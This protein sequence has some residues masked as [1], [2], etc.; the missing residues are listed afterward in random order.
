MVSN[1]TALWFT[2][3]KWLQQT[4]VANPAMPNQIAISF[5]FVLFSVALMLLVWRTWQS[6]AFYNAVAGSITVLMLAGP[7]LQVGSAYAYHGR[8]APRLETAEVKT[9]EQVAEESI[10]EYYASEAWHPQEN[11]LAGTPDTLAVP[12]AESHSLVARHSSLV[13]SNTVTSTLDTDNDGVSD[14]LEDLL[15]LCSGPSGTYCTGVTDSTD[16]DGD[17][18]TDGEEVNQLGTFGDRVDSDNDGISDYLEVKGFSYNGQQWYLDPNEQDTNRDGRTDAQ[19]CTIWVP[20][21]PTY[22]ASG[23]CPDSNGNGTPD[24]FDHDNDG[25]G[26]P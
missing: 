18:L 11:P 17:G 20:S 13:A 4:A 6:R 25:D 5:A 24:V 15:E 10:G 26:V 14:Q 21:D 7:F 16:S 23:I 9:D 12:E 19:E 3:Q 8:L 1:P 2:P 22:N